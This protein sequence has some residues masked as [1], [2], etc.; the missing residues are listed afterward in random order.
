[1][2]IPEQVGSPECSNGVGVLRWERF[3]WKRRNL[4]EKM[5]CPVLSDFVAEGGDKRRGGGPDGVGQH[6]HIVRG[7]LGRGV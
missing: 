6:G 3:T 2:L 7:R 1:V 4:K 5:R